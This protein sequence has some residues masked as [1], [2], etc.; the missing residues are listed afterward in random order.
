MAGIAAVGA[1]ALGAIGS[2]GGGKDDERLQRNAAAYSLALQGD[3]AALTFLGCMAGILPR[4]NVPGYG[5]CGGWATDRAK[6]DAAEKYNAAVANSKGLAIHVA[7]PEPSILDKVE[8]IAQGFAREIG[9]AAGASASG[10]T[11]G[12]AVQQVANTTRTIVVL[13]AV[14]AIAGIGFYIYKNR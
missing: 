6:K 14:A 11:T 8:T 13:L 3:E 7:T 1:A 2:L 5:D 9:S 10:G 12:Q 4:Q